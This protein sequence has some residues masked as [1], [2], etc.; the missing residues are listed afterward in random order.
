MPRL[1]KKYDLDV[2]TRA[3]SRETYQGEAYRSLGLPPAPAVMVE[4]EIVGQGP[5]ISEE[6]LEAAIRRR[7]G[8]PPLEP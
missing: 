7:L 4:D 8:L 1:G 3:K 2:E 5:E 6:R